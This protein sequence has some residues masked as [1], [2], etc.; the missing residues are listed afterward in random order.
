MQQHWR[1]HTQRTTW[2]GK[3]LLALLFQFLFAAAP[4]AQIA[5]VDAPGFTV[6]DTDR[7]IEFF[8]QVLSFEKVSDLEVTGTEYERLQGIFGLRN[9]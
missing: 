3:I 5:A 1:N 6:S 9:G 7:S 8:Q 2:C 4:V